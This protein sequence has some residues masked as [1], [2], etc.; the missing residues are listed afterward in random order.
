MNLK[1]ST[2]LY[3]FTLKI[4]RKYSRNKLLFQDAFKLIN[5]YSKTDFDY[6]IDIINIAFESIVGITLENFAQLSP[7]IKGSHKNKQLL[8]DNT[9]QKDEYFKKY[10]WNYENVIIDQKVEQINGITVPKDSKFVDLSNFYSIDT[11]KQFER[12]ITSFYYMIF[13]TLEYILVRRYLSPL[14]IYKVQNSSS[15]LSNPETSKIMIVRNDDNFLE[16]ELNSD[17]LDYLIKSL[18]KIKRNMK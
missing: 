18:S 16:L 3:N 17:D 5:N 12:N 13:D 11:L 4:L 1:H 15:H 7:S 14:N 8:K 2:N 6:H 10:H 9:L